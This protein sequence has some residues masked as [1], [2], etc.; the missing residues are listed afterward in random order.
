MANDIEETDNIDDF[1][2]DLWITGDKPHT[3]F[4][5]FLNKIGYERPEQEIAYNREMGMYAHTPPTP[6]EK[7]SA[8][9]RRERD[10][11]AFKDH[12]YTVTKQGTFK[13]S[14]SEVRDYGGI[15]ERDEK[16]WVKRDPHDPNKR[17]IIAKET[18]EDD[19]DRY[20]VARCDG[21]DYQWASRVLNP[22]IVVL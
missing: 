5:A 10:R 8:E 14:S 15:P 21:V 11:I 9:A 19:P 22:R 18:D 1:D 3:R 2:R 16:G 20:E 6:Y 4:D 7:A 12:T 13:F 17:V